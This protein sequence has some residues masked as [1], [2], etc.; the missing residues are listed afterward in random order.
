MATP[1]YSS[2][3]TLHKTFPVYATYAY[4]SRPSFP[5]KLLPDD[6]R[7]VAP[8]YPR[9]QFHAQTAPPHA[10]NKPN[11]ENGEKQAK[12]HPIG[13]LFPAMTLVGTPLVLLTSLM[14]VHK[15]DSKLVFEASKFMNRIQPKLFPKGVKPKHLLKFYNVGKNV[16]A[17]GIIPKTII[18]MMYGIKA[19]QPSILFAHL[20]QLPIT[21]LIMRENPIATSLGYMMGGL[22]TLGF[23]N[24]IENGQLKDGLKVG[25]TKPRKYDMS[26]MRSVFE[27]GPD[28]LAAR[29]A[30]FGKEA[31]K[32]TGFVLQDHWLTSKRA[33]KEL[34]NLLTGKKSA[35]TDTES[36]GSISKSSLGFML[37]YMATIPAILSSIFLKGKG[38]MAQHISRFSVGLTIL[39]GIFLNFG[40]VLVAL[41]GKN[42]AERIPLVGTGMELSGTLA[43]Y[44]T[45][46][47]IQPFAV[48]FQQLGAGL[49]TIFYANKAEEK[50]D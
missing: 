26:A 17:L 47:R 40:M 31:G 4:P 3:S 5:G 21:P 22:F 37:A 41:A 42:W 12:V 34:G 24:D 25:I 33:L 23:I 15:K 43:G 1:S 18:G 20:L 2:N 29:F 50:S 6:V 30:R 7:L 8:S 16:L 48:A 44:S 38:A 19:E 39:S 32:M 45:N 14:G 10:T 13:F 35:L 27:A 36:T 11:Q 46:P 49:N 28:S 9:D